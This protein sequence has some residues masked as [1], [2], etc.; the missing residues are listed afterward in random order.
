M[1]SC[2]R[3]STAEGAA[4]SAGHPQREHVSACSYL[5]PMTTYYLIVQRARMEG[6]IV[7]DYMSRAAEAISALAGWV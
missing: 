5:H 2:A 3:T 6:F 7:L 4:P 1:A